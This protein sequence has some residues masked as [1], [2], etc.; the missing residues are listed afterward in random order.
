MANKIIARK[1]LALFDL[2][3]LE[4][5]RFTSLSLADQRLCL[6]ARAMIKQPRLLL[7]DEPCQGLD[8]PQR[9]RVQSRVKAL[10]E[11]GNTTLIYVSHYD[12]ERIAVAQS[13]LALTNANP[14]P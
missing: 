10:L 3:A 5:T 2:S 1:W 14:A 11:N 9:D 4:N 12:E 8:E 13:E 6:I 7:L